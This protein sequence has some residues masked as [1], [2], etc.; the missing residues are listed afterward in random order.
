[1]I[2]NLVIKVTLLAI[3][4]AQIFLGL[5]LDSTLSWNLHVEQMSSK[6]NSACYPIRLPKSIIST[7]NLRTVY[8]A[9]VHSIITYGIIFW[10]NSP[11]SNNIF[12]VQKRVIK[13]IMKVENRVSCRELFKKLNILHC[14]RSTYCRYYY[15]WLRI[16]TYLLLIM[17]F[18]Q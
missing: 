9:Y 11:Y 13:I 6:L 12:K 16:W 10:G 4:S 7:N 2:C 15:L 14:T 5:T 18:T 17:M 3:L 1:M 8:F